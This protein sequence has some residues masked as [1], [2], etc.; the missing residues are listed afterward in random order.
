MKHNRPRTRSVEFAVCFG[1]LVVAAFRSPAQ[2][3]NT[4][5]FN[6]GTVVTV[7]GDVQSVQQHKCS[8]GTSGDPAGWVGT[9]AL[10]GTEYGTLDVHFGPSVFLK[11]H[12][13]TIAPGDDLEVTGS[14]FAG[15]LPVTL[16]VTEVRK[17][18]MFLELRDREGRPLWNQTSRK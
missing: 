16:I 15:T 11:A 7:K 17:G 14:K 18:N 10:L 6:P 8:L 4:P 5:S 13:I 2:Q 3:N 1:L 9:R 12:H